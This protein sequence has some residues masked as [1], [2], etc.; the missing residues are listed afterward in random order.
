[1]FIFVILFVFSSP[2]WLLSVSKVALDGRLGLEVLKAK[3]LEF[4]LVLLDVIMPGIDGLEV[5]VRC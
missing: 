2:F 4:S 3:P 1:M 5:R